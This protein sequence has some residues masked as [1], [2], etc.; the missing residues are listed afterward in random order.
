MKRVARLI[1]LF[2]ILLLF[3]VAALV[4]SQRLLHRQTERLRHEAVAQKE[5]QFT[6]VLELAGLGPP[7]WSGDAI[8]AIERVLDARIHTGDEADAAA[9]ASRWQ[10][11][12]EFAGADGSSR[13][14][15]V[16]NAPP[17]ARLLESTQAIAASLLYLA[18]G[19]IVVFVAF[20]LWSVRTRDSADE[21]NGLER[22]QARA[23]LDNLSQLASMSVRQG[24]ELERERAERLRAEE[25][26]NIKQLLLTR[27][28]EQRIR[29]GQDLHD[30]IIQSLYAT[31]LTLEAARA[32]IATDPATADERLSGVTR[33]LNTTIRDVRAYISGLSPDALRHQTFAQAVDVLTRELG[34]GR[35]TRFN[36]SI[37][38][39]LVSGLGDEL[40]ADLLQIVREAVSNSLRH[41][42]A[43]EVSIS[44]EAHEAGLRLIIRDDGRGFGRIGPAS[45]GHGLENM[46]SRARRHGGSVSTHSV[47]DRGSTITCDIPMPRTGSPCP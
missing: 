24:A 42:A 3:F 4:V 2:S 32:L 43:S 22:A 26:L 19:V 31:G 35:V 25:D 17:A 28:L 30:G 20:L 47:P 44:L 13:A 34:S 7:P 45:S 5:R 27:S 37:D 16:F 1:G 21:T 46:R 15:V 36:V 12:R 33:A 23:G 10:F 41:G 38:P 39:A 6:A 14:T 29:L 40:E 11:T 18:L 8:I 9:H